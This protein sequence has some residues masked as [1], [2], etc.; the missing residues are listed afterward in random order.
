[1]I[2][3]DATNFRWACTGGNQSL[4]GFLRHGRLAANCRLW[5]QQQKFPDSGP[6]SVRFALLDARIAA[7][8]VDSDAT[9][10]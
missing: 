3:L 6:S 4:Y 5:R 9:A 10:L 7:I 8:F 2:A 1:L